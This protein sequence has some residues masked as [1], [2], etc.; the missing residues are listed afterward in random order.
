MINKGELIKKIRID[1]GISL[2]S[3]AV[4][5]C[6]SS[7]LS[8]IE[9][10]QVEAN[11]TILSKLFAKL[12]LDEELLEKEDAYL[13][14]L[15]QRYYDRL[16]FNLDKRE[17]CAIIEKHA[18]LL[19]KSGYLIFYHLVEAFG[20]SNVF[21]I[22]PHE[23]TLKIRSKL[24]GLLD[25][26]NDTE[27]KCIYI[28]LSLSEEKQKQQRIYLN[29]ALEIKKDSL[30]LFLLADTYFHTGD[31][32]RVIALSQEAYLVA[33]LEGNVT[34]MY[35]SCLIIGASYSNLDSS[36]DL[37][38][39][40][41]E[42]ALKLAQFLSIDVDFG[43]YYNIGSTY[44][45]KS[46]LTMA[47]KYLIPLETC[48]LTNLRTAFFLYHKL[49]TLY[50]KWNNKVK[51]KGFITKMQDCIPEFNEQEKALVS[52]MILILAIQ[53]EREDYLSNPEYKKGLEAIYQNAEKIFHFGVKNF[54][55]NDIQT[56]YISERRYKDLYLI[57]K[58]N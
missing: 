35:E 20:D 19:K 36:N 22:K 48:E 26:A 7:F 34:M 2:A 43:V 58:A 6:T 49:A 10:N 42:R 30:S 44:L 52:K 1:N 11:E 31:Y 13:G 24:V 16:F 4:D 9:N 28:Y 39:T 8:K 17:L 57:N 55:K 23:K 15:S 3:L 32:L 38:F 25:C 27:K 12:G 18:N 46:D 54:Y 33:S 29:Q 45:E 21:M 41:Y 14:E 50:L 51:T 47:A 40:Y 5:I 53:V 56:L 37:Q